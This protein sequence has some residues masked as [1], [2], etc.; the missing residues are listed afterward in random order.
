MA[1]ARA[2]QRL[3]GWNIL[4]VEDAPINQ[5]VARTML[6]NLGA[7][8]DIAADGQLM[9]YRH[10]GFWQPMD[11]YQEFMLLNRMWSEGRAPW[12]VW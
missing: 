9:G 4:L 2:G 5:V 12:K 8:V 1:A 3:D 7:E 11:T 10:E 6:K